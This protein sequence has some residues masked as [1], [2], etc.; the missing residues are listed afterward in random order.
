MLPVAAQRQPILIRDTTRHAY[1]L[2]TKT[3]TFLQRGICP[4][5]IRLYTA[6]QKR[7]KAY[8]CST[9]NFVVTIYLRNF[10]KIIHYISKVKLSV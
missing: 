3:L 9:P 6:C 4:T 5:G 2:N 10:P 1:K 8:I 7:C